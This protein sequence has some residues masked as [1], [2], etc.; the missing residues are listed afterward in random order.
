MLLAYLIYSDGIGTIIRMAVIYGSEI[1]IGSDTLL[2]SIL[3][4]QFIGIP[5]AILFGRIAGSIGA[6]SGIF[7]GLSGYIA[8]AILGYFIQTA[9][10]FFLLAIL[11]ATVQGGTQALSRSLFASLIPKHKS[12][13]FF[14]FFAVSERFAGILGPA[15]FASAVAMSGSSRYAVLS[16]IVFFIIGGIVLSRVDPAQG[17]RIPASASAGIPQEPC[18][19]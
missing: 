11:I 14:A 4:V 3:L 17:R 16:I 5:F 9:L 6:R 10:H 15:V 2:A 12:A 8:V 7:I 19:T 1:G 13:E 18:T